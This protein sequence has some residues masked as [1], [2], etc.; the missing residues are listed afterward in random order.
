MILTGT[1]PQIG[2]YYGKPNLTIHY[3]N[4][5][6]VGSEQRVVDCSKQILPLQTGKDMLS[7]TDVAGVKCY[8][9]DQCVPPSVTD[10]SACTDG[11]VQL[12]GGQPGIPEG[13]INYCYKGTWSPLCNLGPKEAAVACRQLGYTSTNCKLNMSL[14][15]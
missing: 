10:G 12:M 4:V 9:P 1:I 15:I 3:S 7:Q 14:L 6:C 5:A 11:D 2:S 13:I 8:T